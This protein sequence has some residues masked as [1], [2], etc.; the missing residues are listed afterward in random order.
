MRSHGILA[1]VL[2]AAAALS[3]GAGAGSGAPSGTAVV[4]A[5]SLKESSVTLGG[6]LYRVAP[7]TKLLDAKGKPIPLAALPV[8]QV[9]RDDGSM[10]VSAAVFFEATEA[11]S[12]W[13]LDSV[14][15]VGEMPR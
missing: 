9:R 6:V 4:E 5:K 13:V 1:A 10:D 11:G 3:L 2:V 14:R 7:T 8:A 15:V 12:G